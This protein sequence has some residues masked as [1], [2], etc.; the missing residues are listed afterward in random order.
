MASGCWL[1]LIPRN[2]SAI[3]AVVSRMR[4]MH[5]GKRAER[6]Y[7]QGQAGHWGTQ[8]S[9]YPFDQCRQVG[10]DGQRVAA[11]AGTAIR[12]VMTPGFPQ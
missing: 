11:P 2:A 8:T 4:W 5:W 3:C 6:M 9:V 1:R 7:A 10:R 12:R